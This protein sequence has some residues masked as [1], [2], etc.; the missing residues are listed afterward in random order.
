MHPRTAE[1][2]G[3]LDEADGALRAAYDAVP[4]ARRAD[5]PAPDRWS[6]AEIVH[7]LAIVERRVTQRIAALVE[8]ARA[9][10]PEP[11]A[12]P[13]LPTLMARRLVDRTRR[14]VAAE[15]SHPHDTEAA[16]AWADLDDA[17][18]ALKAIVVGADGLALGRVSAPHPALGEISGYEWIAFAGAHEARHA[19]Q[20][21]EIVAGVS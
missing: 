13:V 11:D 17:R 10:P 15:A 14:I 20:I 16:R 9:L 8:Q 3:Y 21:R 19:A 7:H 1:L 18:R 6:P 12:S 4:A 5:R 2:L